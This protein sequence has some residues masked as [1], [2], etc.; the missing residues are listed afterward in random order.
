MLNTPLSYLAPPLLGAFIGYM[1]NYVAIKMLFRPLKPWKLFG[2]RIPMTPGV[3]PS[4]RQDLARNIGTM[5]GSHLLTSTDVSQALN[6]KS[7]QQELKALVTIRVTNILNR[8]LGPLP[9][10]IPE[11]F[12]SYFD[13]GVKILLWRTLKLLHG[14][15]NSDSFTQ[16]LTQTIN[17]NLDE[18]LG[19]NLNN[20]LPEEQ[21]QKIFSFIA[22]T[23]EGLMA[24]PEVEEWISTYLDHKI[25]EI[26]N[27]NASL[28]KILPEQLPEL[29]TTLV[30]KE[31][32]AIL[33][34]ISL[35]LNEPETQTRIIN[36]I[37]SAINNF[38][39]SLGPMAAL[40][41]SFLSAEMIE[42]KVQEY[43]DDKGDD[44]AEWLQNQE[45]RDKLI[46]IFRQ[47]IAAFFEQPISDILSGL[48]LDAVTDLRQEASKQLAK[49][50]QS[51]QTTTLIAGFIHDAFDSQSEKKLSETFQDIFGENGIKVGK[52]WA[53]EEIISVLRSRKVK[54]LLDKMLTTLVKEKL[55]SRPIGTLSQFLPKAVQSGF[56]DYLLQLTNALLIKEVPGL[57][58]SLNIEKIVTLKVNSLDLLHLEGLL[59]SIMEE[60][61]KYINIFGG[62]L[63]FIIGLLNLIFIL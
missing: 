9:S 46:T 32:P 17:A 55:L 59:L 38:V 57:V 35:I 16:V 12:R 21:R 20:Y 8:D 4:K 11:H 5:V 26:L 22:N 42:T 63:G 24:K 45:M 51:K 28:N 41:S 39:E 19:N 33:E 2:I 52:K 53:S 37:T 29:L 58:D 48:E 44:I 6:K 31:A 56:V 25:Q 13:A 23:T 30:E 3:I 61:F 10:I 60:Q 7:F 34:K 1:T 43:L 54:R 15:L 36:G 18:L 49:M 50:V 14:H 27:S 47:K 40:A 62:F